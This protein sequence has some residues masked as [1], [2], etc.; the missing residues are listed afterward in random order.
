MGRGGEGE[1]RETRETREIRK[2]W[3][4]RVASATVGFPDRLRLAWTRRMKKV[5]S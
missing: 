4:T 1:T 2:T 5:L 3:G